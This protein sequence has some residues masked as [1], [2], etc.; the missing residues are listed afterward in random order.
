MDIVRLIGIINNAHIVS[1]STQTIAVDAISDNADNDADYSN[2]LSIDLHILSID[3]G[4]R[5][6]NLSCCCNET[7]I[8]YI[9]K[10]CRWQWCNDPKARFPYGWG[11][12][13]LSIKVISIWFNQLATVRF[14]VY[15]RLV[16]YVNFNFGVLILLLI[17]Y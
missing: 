5:T 9:H 4:N 8:I 13:N 17:N 1:G 16:F 2:A 7:N 14:I 6:R 10:T 15:I 11:N 12:G 3:N